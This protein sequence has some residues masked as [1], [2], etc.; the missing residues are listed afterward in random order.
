MYPISRLEIERRKQGL[1][2]KALA[3]QM[4]VNPS[5]VVTMETRRSW[6]KLRATAAVVL[7][8]PESELFTEDGWL[9]KVE[10]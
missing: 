3:A 6:P 8:V 1:T 5:S 7:N 2:K 10:L 9:V 4:G